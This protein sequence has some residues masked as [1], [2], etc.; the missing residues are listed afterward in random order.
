MIN[1]NGVPSQI[2]PKLFIGATLTQVCTGLHEVILH[3]D[4][5]TAITIECDVTGRIADSIDTFSESTSFG[6]WVVAALGRKIRSI[7]PKNSKSLLLTF[8]G[9]FSMEIHDSNAPHYES[10]TVQNGKTVIVV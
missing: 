4:N 1:M 6:K 7:E 2:D 5:G 3:F 9:D 10:F 8:D